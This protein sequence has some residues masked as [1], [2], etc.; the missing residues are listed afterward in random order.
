MNFRHALPKAKLLDSRNQ[1][2]LRLCR[3]KTVLHLGFV[4]EGLL[5][6]RLRHEDWLHA[7]LTSVAARVVGIDISERGVRRA[8]QVGYADCYVGDVER[9]SSIPFPRVEYDIILAADIIE[10]LDNPG[11]FLAE[12]QKV[13]NENTLVVITTPNALNIKT[14]FYP[15]A[16]IECVHPDHNLYCSPTTLSTLLEKHGFQVVEMNL[17][18]NVYKPNKDKLAGVTDRIA[19]YAFRMIDFVLRY[20]LVQLFPHYRID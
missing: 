9:L 11:L 10:H 14:F 5:D 3:G 12:L 13:A 15:L 4:D 7:M 19:K 2:L 16:R 18:S 1:A 8:H 20:S 17:Y 6:D